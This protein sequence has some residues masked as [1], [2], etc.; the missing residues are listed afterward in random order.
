MDY[1]VSNCTGQVGQLEASKILNLAWKNGINTLDTA[2]VYGE[3][4][5]VLGSIGIKNWNIISK[6]PRI[7]NGLRDIKGW[8]LKSIEDSLSRLNITCLN[9]LLLHFPEDLLGSGG[10][11]LLSALRTIKNDGLVK[12]LGV[13]I[14]SP[15]QLDS[16]FR[17]TTFDIVQCPLNL[18]DRRLVDSGW[19]QKLE[20]LKIEIHAR[21]SFLQGLLLMPETCRPKIFTKWTEVWKV[22][23]EWLS[24]T[25]VSP[26]VG[27]LHYAFSVHEANR[28]VIGLESSK[29]LTEVLEACFAP[30]PEFP[31]W[32]MEIPE[33]LINPSHWPK[34]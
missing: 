22:W 4:E 7:P 19:A 11:Q 29:Q 25:G 18:L 6:L 28:I 31:V 15:K 16:L 8:V 33:S 9:G 23:D 1:G 12:K 10:D 5:L 24:A 2:I 26:L 32:R 17:I 30:M 20:K 13:S 14:Y 27:C 21:S 3:S 34:Q